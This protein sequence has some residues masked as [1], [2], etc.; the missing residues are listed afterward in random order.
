MT[1]YL[2]LL[3]KQNADKAFEQQFDLPIPCVHSWQ[4]VVYWSTRAGM[5]PVCWEGWG[6]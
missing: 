2:T 4:D 1:G 5:V 3:A 6:K